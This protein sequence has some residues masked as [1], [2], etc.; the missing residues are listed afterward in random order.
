[1]KI[2]FL[3]GFYVCF[4]VVLYLMSLVKTEEFL[5]VALLDAYNL[6]KVVLHLFM[7]F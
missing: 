7:I 1:L 6:G 5:E 3:G 4:L 2:G